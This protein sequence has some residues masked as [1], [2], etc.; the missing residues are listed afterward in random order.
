M[1]DHF[2]EIQRIDSLWPLLIL[3][4]TLVS[5]WILYFRLHE[6]NLEFFYISV[7]TA[8]LL[9]GILVMTKLTTR[10]DTDGIYFRL[11]PFQLRSRYIQWHEIASVEVRNYKPIKEFG[12]WGLR[13]SRDGKAYSVRGN[14]GIQ[15]TLKD[16]KRILIGT[17]RPNEAKEVV[18]RLLP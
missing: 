3:A 15:L 11:F 17:Q 5:N 4:V 13:W 1:R 16:K 8:M 6:S 2:K 10:I 12:G 9:S 14:E 18:E 7:S